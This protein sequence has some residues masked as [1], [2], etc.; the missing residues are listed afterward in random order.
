MVEKWYI[1]P[2]HVKTENKFTSEQVFEGL[3]YLAESLK[4]V[5]SGEGIYYFL[6]SGPQKGPK[7]PVTP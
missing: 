1:F 3:I 5:L 7:P 6:T 4:V 2:I